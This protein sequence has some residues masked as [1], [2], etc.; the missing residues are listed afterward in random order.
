MCYNYRKKHGGIINFIMKYILFDMDGVL[1][2]SEPVIMKSATDAL[3]HG[4]IESTHDDFIPYIG[5]GEENFIIGPCT[6]GNKEN[7]IDEL[8]EKMFQNFEDNIHEMMVFESA[9]PLIDELKTLGYTIALVSSAARRKLIAS[10]NAA[11]IDPEK[12]SV[13]LSGNDVTEK[14][15]SPQPYLLAAEKL[16]ADPSECIVIEDAISGVKSAKSAGMTCFAV[17]TSFGS[18]ELKQAGA[19]IVETDIIKVLDFLKTQ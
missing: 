3:R 11:G 10:L 12:F 14:K 9:R 13:I 2:N 19:D 7:L 6:K 4:N 17:T 1:V 5:S 15:P 16:S 18:D 8:M